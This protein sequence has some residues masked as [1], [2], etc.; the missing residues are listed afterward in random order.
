MASSRVR[1]VWT[2]A[3]CVA[4][5]AARADDPP[6][7][8]ES[9]GLTAPDGSAVSLDAL[10]AGRDATV[11]VFWSAS[12]PCVRRYQERVDALLEA[13]APER[14]RVVAI[15]SN[16]GE[17]FAES[18]ATARERGVRVSLYRDEGGKV[19]EALGARST[20]TAVVLDAKG[21]VRFRGWIDNERRPGEGGR[22]PWLERAVQGVLDG[23]TSFAAKTPVY[24]CRITKSLF[25]RPAPG[26]CCSLK[27]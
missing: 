21:A 13:Y 18:L 1:Y 14:V 5:A 20:P 22:E 27:H 10:R 12:C 23:K 6:A 3:A 2:F 19:A 16:A 15:S 11:V 26:S 9:P 4:A 24:G 17:E 7:R 25:D 8:F